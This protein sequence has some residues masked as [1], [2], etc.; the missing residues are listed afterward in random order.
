MS[1]SSRKR[2]RLSVGLIGL[3]RL[4]RVYARDLSTRIGG[5]TH[6]HLFPLLLFV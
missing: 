4:G 5:Y 6:S 1:V 2:Q 3:G